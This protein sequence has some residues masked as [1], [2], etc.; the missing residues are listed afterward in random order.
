[1]ILVASST[2]H[3][4]AGIEHALIASKTFDVWQEFDNDFWEFRGHIT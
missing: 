2:V 3:G 1:V 4:Y